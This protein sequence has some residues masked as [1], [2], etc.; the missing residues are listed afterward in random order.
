MLFL[1]ILSWTRE[2]GKP[3]LVPDDAHHW[4]VYVALIGGTSLTTH[5]QDVP[6]G[7]VNIL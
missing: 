4:R 2:D 7:N 3:F 5:I 6:G 1:V